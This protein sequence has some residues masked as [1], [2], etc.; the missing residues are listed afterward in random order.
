MDPMGFAVSFGEGNF[1][2]IHVEKSQVFP[3][4]QK[5]VTGHDGSMGR[6]Y[7]YIYPRDPVIFSDDDWGV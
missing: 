4:V 5:L 6:L 2:P 1:Q 3:P 7:I